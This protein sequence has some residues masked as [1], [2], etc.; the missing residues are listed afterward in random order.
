MVGGSGCAFSS[1]SGNSLQFFYNE[2]ISFIVIKN[3]NTWLEL[4]K[5]SLNTNEGLIQF[6]F[7]LKHN[8]YWYTK[9]TLCDR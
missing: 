1:F 8:Y 3:I 4:I 2:Y 9:F 6:T 5:A 7:N